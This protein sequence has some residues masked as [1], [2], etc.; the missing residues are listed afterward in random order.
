MQTLVDF[1]GQSQG[2]LEQKP[3]HYDLAPVFELGRRA[4]AAD[5]R[6]DGPPCSSTCAGWVRPTARWLAS[7]AAGRGEKRLSRRGRR[8]HTSCMVRSVRAGRPAT[9]E[10]SW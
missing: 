2:P 6:L 1:V 8:S 5:R 10:W 7:G 3:T 9:A 4:K